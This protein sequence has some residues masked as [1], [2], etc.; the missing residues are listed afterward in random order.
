MVKQPP[1]LAQLTTNP[2]GK[3]P[4]VVVGPRPMTSMA[5]IAGRRGSWMPIRETLMFYMHAARGPQALEEH[6]HARA[7][8][9]AD[10]ARNARG[11]HLPQP[12]FLPAP[13]ARA[14]PRPREAM[15]EDNRAIDTDLLKEQKKAAMKIAA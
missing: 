15:L 14:M 7:A 6:Q 3:L 4:P 12:G 5:D 13:G 10:P 9:R 8:Q 2:A 1:V 11:A